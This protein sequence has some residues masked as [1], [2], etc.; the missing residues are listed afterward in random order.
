[1]QLFPV[2]IE[3][4]KWNLLFDIAWE[5]VLAVSW[6]SLCE[7]EL[8]AL[9]W[10]PTLLGLL[11]HSVSCPREKHTSY[12]PKRRRP[13]RDGWFSKLLAPIWQQGVRHYWAKGPVT[14]TAPAKRHQSSHH[15]YVSY[16]PADRKRKVRHRNRTLAR[17][18]QLLMIT[19]MSASAVD[20][21][22]AF[23]SDSFPISVDNCSSRTL[24]NSRKDFKP[25]TI[26]PCNI[27]VTGISGTVRCK[28]QGTVTWKIEDDQGR[29][30]DF[31][32]ENTPLCP[33][34]PH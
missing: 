22:Y 2:T 31:E 6:A 29:A 27:S 14:L 16:S 12:V 24:T 17:S 5:I 21:A 34:L 26:T 3:L 32:V 33:S 15:R 19:C 20:H 7:G 28:L 13:P 10:M 8:S 9:T 30:H 18:L 1:M 4:L 23:D 11:A 25:G